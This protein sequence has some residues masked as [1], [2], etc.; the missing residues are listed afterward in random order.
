MDKPSGSRA[1]PSNDG[2]IDAPTGSAGNPAGGTSPQDQPE[3]QP[4]TSGPVQRPLLFAGLDDDGAYRDLARI[5][6]ENSE[7][8][9]AAPRTETRAEPP[10]GRTYRPAVIAALVLIAAALTAVLLF[11]DPSLR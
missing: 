7:R 1:P 11:I 5:T 4:Q 3:D 9:H 6:L 2:T 8:S 10:I